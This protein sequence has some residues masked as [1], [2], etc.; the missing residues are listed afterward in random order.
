MTDAAATESE[1][2]DEDSHEHIHVRFGNALN[3]EPEEGGG[4]GEKEQDLL[5]ANQMQLVSVL[6]T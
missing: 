2:F 6:I 3:R 1:P 5:S 4:G